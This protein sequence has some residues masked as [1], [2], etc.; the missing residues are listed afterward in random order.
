MTP[1]I[2]N[3]GELGEAGFAGIQ[4]FVGDVV[5]YEEFKAGEPG[6]EDWRSDGIEVHCEN[7]Q[8]VESDDPN[9][10][11]KDNK[12]TFRWNT[13]SKK[14]SGWGRGVLKGYENLGVKVPE[15]I[16]QRT[17]FTR[18]EIPFG[19][20]KQTDGTVRSFTWRNF[21]P[22]SIVGKEAP[23]VDLISVA[24]ELA[25]GKTL[26]QFKK[27]AILHPQIRQDKD[28]LGA[29]KDGSFDDE[30]LVAGEDGML[31]VKP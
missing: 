7:V 3:T 14:N 28:L 30:F 21:V 20:K 9:F 22:T 17:E 13:S 23:V 29:I 6:F 18:I 27:A 16:C 15:E 11:L 4:K 26:A 1:I 5:S 8:V 10:Q 19:G 24:C 31:A 12:F 2:W 25:V